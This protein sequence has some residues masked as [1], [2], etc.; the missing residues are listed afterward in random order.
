MSTIYDRKGLKIIIPCSSHT[1]K[2]ESINKGI[3][4]TV[5]ALMLSDAPLA[6]ETR[7]GI[8]VLM[9][10]LYA[11]APTEAILQEPTVLQM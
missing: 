6:R 1:A 3:I 5:K 4:N 8:A 9:E 7:E 10:L 2:H 11:T